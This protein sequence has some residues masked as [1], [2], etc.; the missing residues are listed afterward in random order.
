MI[1]ELPKI[2]WTPIY[3]P[4]PDRRWYQFWKSRRVFNPD[5][6]GIFEEA[7]EILNDMVWI[8]KELS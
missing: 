4:N 8:D 5:T 6:R 2:S 7:N 3:I 1:T